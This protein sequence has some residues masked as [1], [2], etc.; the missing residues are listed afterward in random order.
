MTLT[1]N[2]SNVLNHVVED[3]QAWADH[4]EAHFGLETGKKFMLEKVEK[5]E[6]SYLDSQGDG[7][8]TRKQREDASIIA[9]QER[10]DNVSW[11]VKRQREYP[12]ALEL[13]VALY[14]TDDKAD[15]DKRRAEV[16]AKYP[17]P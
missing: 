1:E 8:Q 10:Y 11:D 13:I 4:A 9:E 14:D 7:Y 3:G 6:Q 16:K 12:T 17:K 5:Y 2:Q 15:V